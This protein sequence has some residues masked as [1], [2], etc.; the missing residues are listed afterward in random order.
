MPKRS[1]KQKSSEPVATPGQLAADASMHADD[2]AKIAGVT[3][4][5]LRQLA[6]EGVIPKPKKNLYPVRET[7]QGLFEYYRQKAEQSDV[8]KEREQ[9][10][11]RKIRFT[12]EQS[13]G[14]LVSIDW[15]VERF[16]KVGPKVRGILRQKLEVEWP[17]A[18]AGLEVEQLRVYGK[19]TVDAVLTEIGNLAKEFEGRKGRKG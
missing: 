1:A 2:V 8:K 15:I 17:S 5:R 19:R 3:E 9:E 12:N 14:N 16:L 7:F 6:A 11:L 10:E 18:A 13:F 4:R